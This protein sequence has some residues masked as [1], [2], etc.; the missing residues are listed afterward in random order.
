MKFW[1]ILAVSG[2]AMLLLIAIGLFYVGHVLEMNLGSVDV[3]LNTSHSYPLYVDVDGSIDAD[4]N[5]S[6]SY[7]LY[8][9]AD[10]DLN[11][12]YSSPLYVDADLNS[13]H[14]NPVYVYP[15]L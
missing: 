5:S 6:S 15:L 7:P 11:S 2:V 8:V 9:D 4:L 3:D 1:K 12:T 13:T 10:V 14:N